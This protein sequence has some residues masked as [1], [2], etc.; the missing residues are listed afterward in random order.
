MV[1]SAMIVL[2][3]LLVIVAIMAVDDAVVEPM[4]VKRKVGRLRATAG[5]C[6]PVRVEVD[7]FTR[8]CD[9]LFA[10][11]LIVRGPCFFQWMRFKFLQC[12]AKPSDKLT[13]SWQ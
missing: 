5:S 9:D 12:G 10:E 13:S 7:V 2:M 1:I 6:Q 3:S 8:G 11:V 4:T